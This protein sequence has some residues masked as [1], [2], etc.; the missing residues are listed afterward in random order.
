MIISILS[1][2]VT[3]SIVVFVHELGHF[4]IARNTGVKVYVFSLGFGPELIGVTHKGIRYRLSAFPLGGYV[5]MKGENPES[6]DARAS[7]A[8]MGIDPI[9]RL[10]IIVA[11]P[12]MNFIAGMLIFSFLIY[13]W[14]LPMFIDKPIVGGVT[15]DSPAYKAGIKQGDKIVSI[16]NKSISSWQEISTHVGKNKEV[17]LQ[18]KIDRAGEFMMVEIIP[19]INEEMGRALIGI[20]ASFENVKLGFFGSLVEGAKYTIVLCWKLLE[21]L[22]LIITGKMAAAV[23]GPVGIG[24]V[25]TKA[26]SEGIAH[27]LQLIALISVNLGFINLFPIPILDG[28]HIIFA[29]YEKIKGSPLDT[30]K[31]NIANAIGLSMIMAL[32]LFATWQDILRI[33]IGK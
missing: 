28:G 20:T 25:I 26:A 21:T 11:G 15:L 8:F 4:L 22:W 12:V 27:L 32:L 30:K 23:A 33:F 10:G 24:Q 7:D 2:L 16:N 13:V 19:E 18:L 1:I 6:E 9:R 14:G 3:F 31:V 29:V 5:K 17:P